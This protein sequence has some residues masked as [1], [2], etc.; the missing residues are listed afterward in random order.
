MQALLVALLTELG[1]GVLFILGS[2]LEKRTGL[3]RSRLVLFLSGIILATPGLL[4]VFYYTHLFDNAAWFYRFR[5]LSFTEFLP[6]GMG[7]LAGVLYSV[8]DP[9]SLGEKLIVPTAPV[10]LVLIPVV[11]PPPDPLEPHRL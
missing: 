3:R 6:A 7:L 11:K 10:V 9:E 8:F 5:I 4:F 1:S 2:F